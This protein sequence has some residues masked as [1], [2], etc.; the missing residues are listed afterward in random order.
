MDVSQYYAGAW[1]LM[2]EFLLGIGAAVVL[3]M[4][5]FFPSLD[6]KRPAY[7]AL[8]FLVAALG[9]AIL[10]A[11]NQQTLFSGM[12]VVDPFVDFFRIFSIVA[13]ILGIL[14]ALDS[15]EIGPHNTGEYYTL[16]L[17]LVMGMSLM[18]MS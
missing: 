16:F 2:P 13:G 1:L 17:A 4:E 6:G 15:K 12:V 14:I 18:A 8:G 10:V 7:M 11:G 5:A 3:L 9:L